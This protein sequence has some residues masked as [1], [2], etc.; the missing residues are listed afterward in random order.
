MTKNSLSKRLMLI[1]LA[2]VFLISTGFG[3]QGLSSSQ[4]NALKPI[5]L[6]YWTVHDDVDTIRALIASYRT[7]HPQINVNVRQLQAAEFYPRLVEA[8]AEDKGPDII[9]VNNREMRTYL[10][11]LSQMPASVSDVTS[12]I[13]KSQLG[14]SE[15][16]VNTATIPLVT[17]LQL[18][19]EFVPAVKRDVSVGSNIFGLP[20]SLDTMALFYNKDLLDRAGVPEPPKTWEEFQAAVKKMTKY[21]K[22]TGNIIQSGAA[23]GTGNNIPGVDDILM[24]LFRQS[25]VQFTSKSTG[26]VAFNAAPT[27]VSE[28]TTA[29]NVMDFYTDFANS[30]RDTYAW[31]DKSPNALD[32]FVNGSVGFFFGYSYH[33]PVIKARAPQLNFGVLPMLQLNADKPINVASY[34]IQAV[35]DKSKHKNEAW[36]VINFLAHS[37]AT[38]LYLDR[39]GRPTALRTYITAQQV[40]LDLQPFVAQLLIAENWYH[41]QNYSVALTAIK[42]M[43]TQW[44]QPVPDPQKIL[45]YRQGILNNAARKIDQTL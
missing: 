34:W 17:P 28:P 16:V 6:E 1:C 12:Y 42:D 13:K 18:T 5:S 7:T 19:N 14:S 38:K 25:N 8:L 9:S 3:C 39:T 35:P 23:L 26:R 24:M 21:D 33:L 29:M 44:L 10:S 32:A 31:S 41:G 30:N 27:R 40:Q 43:V 20:I 11:K 37:K 45:E 4:Q 2:S 36:G 22:A 15:T